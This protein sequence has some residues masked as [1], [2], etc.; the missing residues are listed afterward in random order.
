MTPEKLTQTIECPG[1]PE[2]YEAV[3][4]QPATCPRC[5]LTMP[6]TKAAAEWKY[7]QPTSAKLINE[8]HGS[9]NQEGIGSRYGRKRD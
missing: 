4:G 2:K 1:C 3:L 6:T 7:R 8:Y 5:D 9:G